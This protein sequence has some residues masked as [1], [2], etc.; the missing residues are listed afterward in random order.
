V[1]WKKIFHQ[2]WAYMTHMDLNWVDWVLVVVIGGSVLA[3]L[4]SGFFKT[5]S[6]LLGLVLGLALATWNYKSAAKIFES[7]LHE[8]AVCDALGFVLIALVVMVALGIIGRFMAKGFKWL[9]LGW[10]DHILGAGIGFLQGSLLVVLGILLMV[11]FFPEVKGLHE[12]RFA[13]PFVAACRGVTHMGPSELG[14]KIRDGLK[15]IEEASPHWM[16]S[17]V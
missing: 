15:K 14:E 9:G 6:S 7:F 12:S 4:A 8:R 1:Q 5:A 2:D 3:G 13:P 11:A 10:L 17:S 16:H